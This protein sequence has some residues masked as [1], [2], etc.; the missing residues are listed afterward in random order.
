MKKCYD[1]PLMNITLCEEE[2]VRTSPVYGKDGT[3]DYGFD[4]W[5][6]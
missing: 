1:E 6:E 3:D 4:F 2:V 5:D